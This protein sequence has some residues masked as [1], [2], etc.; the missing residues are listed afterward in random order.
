M[1]NPHARDLSSLAALSAL[2]S[3]WHVQQ[4]QD[5][6]QLTQLTDLE[7][8]RCTGRVRDLLPDVPMP[9]IINIVL[10]QAV[11]MIDDYFSHWVLDHAASRV[12]NAEVMHFGDLGLR[13]AR[14]G[15]DVIDYSWQ[16]AIVAADQVEPLLEAAPR[17]RNLKICVAL[18]DEPRR[19]CWGSKFTLQWDQV[20]MRNEGGRKVKAWERSRS[21]G[22]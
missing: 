6:S 8:C 7:L 20:A 13:L 3:L 12:P 2:R 9:N 15:S 22:E 16:A 18:W 1:K 14:V 17:L 10:M 11:Y 21:W 19:R 4:P 5:V